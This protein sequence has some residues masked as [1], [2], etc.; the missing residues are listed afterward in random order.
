MKDITVN[1]VDVFSLFAALQ[2]NGVAKLSDHFTTSQNDQDNDMTSPAKGHP[3]MTTCPHGQND[4]EIFSQ[5]FTNI[6]LNL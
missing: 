6:H 4:M 1:K 5:V 2:K 3:D